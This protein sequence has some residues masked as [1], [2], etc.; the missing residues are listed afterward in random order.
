MMRDGGLEEEEGGEL[1]DGAHG[2]ADDFS[3]ELWG[4]DAEDGV[5]EVAEGGAVAGGD[6]GDGGALLLGFLVKASMVSVSPEPEITI[7]KSPLRML[8]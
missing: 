6:E 1:E 5:G 4:A 7:S 2:H 3:E 8:G